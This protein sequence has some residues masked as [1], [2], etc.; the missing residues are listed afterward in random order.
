MTFGDGK[1]ACRGWI[2][3]FQPNGLGL[4]V[5]RLALHLCAQTRAQPHGRGGGNAAEHPLG[6]PRKVATEWGGGAQAIGY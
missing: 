5:G 4:A 1:A 2:A 3:H 6:E